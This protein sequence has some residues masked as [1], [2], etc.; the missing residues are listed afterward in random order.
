MIIELLNNKC[1]LQEAF[2]RY[3]SSDDKYQYKLHVIATR[4][5]FKNWKQ[6]KQC[7]DSQK[8]QDALKAVESFYVITT[9]L[10][11]RSKK[12]CMSGLSI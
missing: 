5:G 9:L 6:F 2:Q 11:K 1:K 3:Y 7:I 8:T 4:T 12:A 10:W